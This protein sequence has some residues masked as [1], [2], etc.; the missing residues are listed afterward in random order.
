MNLQQKRLDNVYDFASD[1]L[2]AR[3][4]RID[5]NSYFFRDALL[6]LLFCIIL[7]PAVIFYSITELD[8]KNF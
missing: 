5:G 4:E 8:L 3:D 1:A 7:V 6:R 2:G